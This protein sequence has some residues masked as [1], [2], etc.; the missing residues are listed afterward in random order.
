[1]S[2]IVNQLSLSNVVVATGG[3]GAQAGDITVSANISWNNNAS[4]TLSAHNNVQITGGVAITNSAGGNL[5]LKADSDGS[6]GGRVI[7]D[8]GT[9]PNRIDWT[10]STGKVSI[11][12][13]PLGGYTNPTNYLTGSNTNSS[14]TAGGKV[15]LG[16]SATLDYYMLVNSAAN[17][18]AVGTNGTTLAQNYALGKGIDLSSIPNFTPMNTFSGKFDGQ[19]FTISNLHVAPVNP[20][21]FGIGVGLFTAVG[22]GGVVKNL[23]LEHA[24]IAANP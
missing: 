6:G 11:Y 23:N 21:N 17:L 4:L 8:A 5:V 7:L 24:T 2:T 1:A 10:N 22:A 16:P 19:N 14:G 18:Q 12:E 9:F 13:N 15:G 3:G 20:V